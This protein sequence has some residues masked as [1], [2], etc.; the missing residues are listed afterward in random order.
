MIFPGTFLHMTYNCQITL[1]KY[2]TH[3]GSGTVESGQCLQPQHP[4]AHST[5]RRTSWCSSS[6]NKQTNKIGCT[7]TPKVLYLEKHKTIRLGNGHHSHGLH[8][9]SLPDLSY[10][11]LTEVPD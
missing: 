4:D 2:V 9:G 5:G 1:G 7:I 10:P 11:L 3:L 6:R 8:Q